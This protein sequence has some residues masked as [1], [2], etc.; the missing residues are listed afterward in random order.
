[1]IW[2]SKQPSN[3]MKRTFRYFAGLCVL[4]VLAMGQSPL[5]NAHPKAEAAL[6]ARVGQFY[7]LFQQGKFR[8]AEEFVAEDSK[9]I[10]YT[11][12]KAR[13]LGFQIKSLSFSPNEEDATVLVALQMIM[14][15]MG[16]R[17]V[18]IPAASNWRK[19]KGAWYLHYPQYKPGSTVQ[20]PFGPK[21]ISENPNRLEIL[22]NIEERPDLASLRRMYR[23]SAKELRFPSSAP[24]RITQE[25]T[26]INRSEGK[27]SLEQLTK[28]IKGID[29]EID[30]VEADPGEKIR[31]T[32]TYRPAVALHRRNQK[33]R[34]AVS[35]ISQHFSVG[36]SFEK[37]QVSFE[38][39]PGKVYV[40]HVTVTDEGRWS[41]DVTGLKVSQI[42]HIE[43][44][45]QALP[46]GQGQALLGVH[47]G[48]GVNGASDGPRRI[49]TGSNDRFAV[50]FTAPKAAKARILLGYVGGP[51]SVQ[52]SGLK[53]VD[54]TRVHPEI[55]QSGFEAPFVTP[56]NVWANVDA[57]VSAK[58]ARSGKQSLAVRG[59]AGAIYQDSG[60]PL[61][62]SWWAGAW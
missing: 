49:D 44:D 16:T 23:V 56:W 14:P 54:R 24:G 61:Y 42:Y 17:P 6:R 12:N 2:M 59:D 18:S 29:I 58:A 31:V 8:Q 43:I 20:T 13:H 38:D 28:Q 4:A 60:Y 33:V 21:K 48:S 35:P 27:L 51:G 55:T 9:D 22:P 26:V 11:A 3:A 1:M 37:S 45:A 41:L 39:T 25:I 15:M 50:N 19:V 36:L 40:E 30:P 62:S 10:Y 5:Q 32:F 46:G 47:D 53:I 7:T 34:F 52:W 57:Q